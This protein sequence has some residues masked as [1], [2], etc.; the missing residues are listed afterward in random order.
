MA[1][2]G[3]APAAGCHLDERRRATLVLS[4][5]PAVAAA[6]DDAFFPTLGYVCGLRAAAAVPVIT[7]LEHIA[8]SR[9]DLKA[10]SAA[11]G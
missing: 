10:F 1:L 9:D 8:A 2:T 11:F 5:P 4:V 3:R 6:A 7:G